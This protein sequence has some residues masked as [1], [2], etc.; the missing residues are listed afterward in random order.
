MIFMVKGLE[1]DAMVSLEAHKRSGAYIFEMLSLDLKPQ[2][3]LPS[4]H[5]VLLGS[6]DHVLF[7]DITDM[8]LTLRAATGP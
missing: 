7:K 8:L 3:K 6:K 2:P 1:R 5:L 4:E